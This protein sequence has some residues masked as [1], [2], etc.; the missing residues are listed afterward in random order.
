M[1][2]WAFE[3]NKRAVTEKCLQDVVSFDEAVGKNDYTKGICRRLNDTAY[4]LSSYP[5]PNE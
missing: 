4:W 5:M 2:L 3:R 1:E